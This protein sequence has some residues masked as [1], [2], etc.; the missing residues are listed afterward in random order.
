MPAA[1]RR[2]LALAC[3]VLSLARPGTSEEP[4]TAAS[5][6][7]V[8]TATVVAPAGSDVRV[9][10]AQGPETT[11]FTAGPEP[12]YALRWA[13]AAG[14]AP[15]SAEA[16]RARLEAA[17]GLQR[18][19]QVRWERAE[20]GVR[21]VASAGSHVALRRRLAGLAQ[22]PLALRLVAVVDPESAGRRR[23]HVLLRGGV[24]D[25]RVVS[26]ATEEAVAM[27][28]EP[29]PEAPVTA[30][31]VAEG[32]A[33]AC[34]TGSLAEPW[35]AA[36]ASRVPAPAL[37]DALKARH[38]AAADAA[39]QGE[40]L[41][42]LGWFAVSDPQV[43]GLLAAA[44]TGR[45][46]PSGVG[47]REVL[48]DPEHQT[49]EV[50]DAVLAAG[51]GEPA[52]RGGRAEALLTRMA[53][54]HPARVLAVLDSKRPEERTLGLGA[55]LGLTALGHGAPGTL[56]RAAR[57]LDDP[58]PRAHALGLWL[59]LGLEAQAPIGA[60]E[61]FRLVL[62]AR[63]PALT[64]ERQRLFEGGP[65]GAPPPAPPP[66]TGTGR[67]LWAWLGAPGAAP[68]PVSEP[69]AD[70]P[71][72]RCLAAAFAHRDGGST[73]PSEPWLAAL[74]AAD[75]EAR[76]IAAAAAG[77]LPRTTPELRERL[78]AL[79]ADAGEAETVRWLAGAAV[80][81][82]GGAPAPLVAALRAQ[83]K[84]RPADPWAPYVR[85]LVRQSER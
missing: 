15:P 72:E 10:I 37:V 34:S 22:G 80:V 31:D 40:A 76:A 63:D 67:A 2:R 12:T 61:A 25:V 73:P 68:P 4:A 59:R 74:S 45:A 71:L 56:E 20:D 81:A 28:V 23:V 60:P 19:P 18:L 11:L 44:A 30:A 35:V 70:A 42:L 3:L 14:E 75:A 49:A 62:L 9:S 85:L 33:S 78:L 46:S 41:E 66:A 57:L 29:R 53:P 26:A 48:A 77:L 58:S 50:F 8:A 13:L 52:A 32:L 47:A 55:L 84:A 6:W 38:A 16:A 43:P 54:R 83:Q 64:G 65:A 27:R 17:L 7:P 39:A 5:P 69:F 1:P 36:L 79:A 82:G 21:L 24:A 51:A